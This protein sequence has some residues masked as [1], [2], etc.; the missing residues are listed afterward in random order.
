MYR[1]A[2]ALICPGRWLPRVPAAAEPPLSSLR[3]PLDEMAREMTRLLLHAI[4]DRSLPQRGVPLA[5]SLVARASSG[6][7]GS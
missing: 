6:A 7:G 1:A 5:T 4:E 2:G 3:W